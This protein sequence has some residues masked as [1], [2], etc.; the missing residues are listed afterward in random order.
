MTII[1]VHIHTY[2]TYI[3]RWPIRP[4]GSTLIF[5]TLI[6]IRQWGVSTFLFLT[7]SSIRRWVIFDSGSYSTLDRTG[8]WVFST[9]SCLTFSLPTSS[10]STFSRSR[11]S[12]STFSRYIQIAGS[13][14]SQQI[15]KFCTTVVHHLASDQVISYYKL[16]RR[17]GEEGGDAE[18]FFSLVESQLNL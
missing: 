2:I 10:L 3:L 1:Y 15:V 5:F 8:C 16:L 12:S 7:L 11:F 13:G 14:S 6:S 4:S 9:F 18:S 17:G